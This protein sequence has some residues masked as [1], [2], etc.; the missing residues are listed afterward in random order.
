[1]TAR[2]KLSLVRQIAASAAGALI[3]LC[4]A[5][6]AKA[7][8]TISTPPTRGIVEALGNANSD[9]LYNG[10]ANQG[11]FSL[12]DSLFSGYA[13]GDPATHFLSGAGGAHDDLAPFGGDQKVYALLIDGSYDFNYDLGTGLPLHP[14]LAGGMGMAVYG[15]SPASG[16]GFAMQSGDMVPLFRVGG[17][18]TYRLGEQWDLS[19]DYKAGFTG[20]D[21]FITMRNQEPVDMQVLDMGMHYQF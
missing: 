1:M 6:P 14:Y 9:S 19:L 7:D 4:L 20:G 21:Q 12:S 13:A 3:V 11:G 8:T 2:V 17:G 5:A 10:G 15:G 18:V 16:G